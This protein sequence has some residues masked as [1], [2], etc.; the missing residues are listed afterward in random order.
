M[1]IDGRLPV[2]YVGKQRI[3]VNQLKA[4]SM[5][6]VLNPV[7]K[8][9]RILNNGAGRNPTPQVIRRLSVI[10]P[11]YNEQ[12]T[13]AAILDRVAEVNLPQNVEKEIIVVNDCSTDTTDLII[14]DY[15][16]DNSAVPIQYYAHDDNMGKGA[17]IHTGIRYA[18]GDFLLIQDADLEY[19]P[20]E[21]N[22]L[23]API[24]KGRADVVYG[25]R[26][27][28]GSAH[29]ILFFWHSIGNRFLTFLFNACTNQNLTDME[30]GYKI[31]KTSLIRQI[32]LKEQ[33]FG[34]EPEVTAKI[35]AIPGTRVY[36][37]GISYYGR[38]YKEGKKIKWRDGLRTIFC[39]IKYG[40]F[41]GRRPQVNQQTP[42]VPPAIP[43]HTIQ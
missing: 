2:F 14:K 11:A 21:Y 20:A 34:F 42:V 8:Q 38:T 5:D 41:T 28:G 43:A 24:L 3:Q 16:L 1:P 12:R 10:I 37:V 7:L 27:M 39:I 31:F 6:E 40:L 23:L 22:T 18:S 19:D 13:I 29:R 35:A 25:S 9:V 17:A 30:T 32:D 15:I 33:R 36:E 4:F 26:F